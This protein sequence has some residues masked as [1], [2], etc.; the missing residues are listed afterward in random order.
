[1]KKKVWKAPKMVALIPIQNS[2]ESGLYNTKNH[3]V[4]PIE[5]YLLDPDSKPWEND[6]A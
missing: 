6:G 5:T 2:K 4:D 3:K 1:M